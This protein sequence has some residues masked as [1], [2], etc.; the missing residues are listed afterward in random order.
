MAPSDEEED[1]SSD[2]GADNDEGAGASMDRPH[3]TWAMMFCTAIS[4]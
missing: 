4:A 3:M 1:V 2:D